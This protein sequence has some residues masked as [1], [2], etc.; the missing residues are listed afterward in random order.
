MPIVYIAST[1]A[2]TAT[3][4]I[5]YAWNTSD[6]TTT[7]ATCSNEMIWD[8]WNSTS[9][10]CTSTAITINRAWPTWVEAHEETVAEREARRAREAAQRA[11]EAERIR[12]SIERAAEEKKKRDAAEK[13]AAELLREHLSDDQREEFDKHGRFT[14][15]IVGGDG[16]SRRY[17]ICR[18]L[19]GNVKELAADGRAIASFCIHPDVAAFPFHDNM[20]A[21][22]LM[23]ETDEKA[24]RRIANRTE[25]RSFER[26]PVCAEARTVA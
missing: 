6:S 10:A 17:Q 16:Q 23:L 12:E 9:T 8:E 2:T 11:A 25:L 18:G 20:L 13:V 21:Q 24:F 15:G 14:V 22:K 26:P 3:A 19:S 4:V 5:W 1:A 7:A